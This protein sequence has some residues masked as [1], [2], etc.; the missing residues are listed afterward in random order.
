MII[1]ILAKYDK[2]LNFYFFVSI[3]LFKLMFHNFLLDFL[4]H[5]LSF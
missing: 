2:K 1:V 4:L 5:M 3:F